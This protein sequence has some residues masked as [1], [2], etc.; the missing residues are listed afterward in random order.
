[1]HSLTAGFCCIPLC[2]PSVQHC[3]CP[4]GIQLMPLR[5]CVFRDWKG[6]NS[7][8]CSFC[9]KETVPWNY[10][11]EREHFLYL[12]PPKTKYTSYKHVLVFV[13][14]EVIPKQQMSVLCCHLSRAT[15]HKK[16]IY[17]K[18][19]ALHFMSLHLP[20]SLGIRSPCCHVQELLV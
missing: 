4:K 3:T 8:S 13:D 7:H 18:P 5:R 6:S 20:I 1:M 2:F 19:P 12:L 9:E 17:Q 14:W 10:A 11:G 15:W 16:F